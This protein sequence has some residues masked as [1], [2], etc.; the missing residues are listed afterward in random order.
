VAVRAII[1]EPSTHPPNQQPRPLS[2]LLQ[3]GVRV[4]SRLLG[5]HDADGVGRGQRKLQC[6][7]LT[8]I[9]PVNSISELQARA[10]LYTHDHQEEETN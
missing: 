6:G 2:A 9:L 3:R 5:E 1:H 8:L 7:L 4:V 10:N